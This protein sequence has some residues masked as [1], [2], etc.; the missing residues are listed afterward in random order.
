MPTHR[1]FIATYI[2]A[3]GRN[4]TLYVGMTANLVAR[5]WKH[6]SGVFDGFSKAYG[7]TR[8]V[9]FERHSWIVDAIAREKR[10]KKWNRDW[11]LKLIEAANPDWADLAADWYP[12]NDPNWT[13]PLEDD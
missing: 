3:S 6:R 1:T 13:P 4:G 9:W 12:V 2:M 5:V 8:L 7:C 11:K 10:L